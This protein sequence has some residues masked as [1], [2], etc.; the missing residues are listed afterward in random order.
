MRS[1]RLLFCRECA[2]KGERGICLMSIVSCFLII[3]MSIYLRTY[4]FEWT[5]FVFR[6]WWMPVQNLAEWWSRSER[7]PIDKLLFCMECL[8]MYNET[9]LFCMSFMKERNR[10]EVMQM[11]ERN[12]LLSF[13]CN[14]LINYTIILSN[15]TRPHL[16]DNK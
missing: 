7:C 8:R 5:T 14:I 1:R 10:N 2:M 4:L 11:I 16:D 6:I 15:K 9:T 3:Y 13:N 12:K